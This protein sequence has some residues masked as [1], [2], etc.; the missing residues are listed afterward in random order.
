MEPRT[1]VARTLTVESRSELT[2]FRA[3]VRGWIGARA[4]SQQL[5]DIVLA[6]GE[7]VDNA[8][9]HGTPPATVE[10]GWDTTPC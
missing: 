2:E 6:C 9:E 7:A 8:L 1:S 5:D 4:D 10:L 3:D